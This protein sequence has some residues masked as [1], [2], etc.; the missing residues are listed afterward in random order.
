MLTDWIS[1]MGSRHNLLRLLTAL[2]LLN[3]TLCIP[4][5]GHTISTGDF[6]LRLKVLSSTYETING[7]SQVPI[8]CDL[9]NYSAYCNESRNAVG[10]NVMVVQDESG[11]TLTISCV[12]DS[13]W[14]NC[15]P[16]PVGATF[17]AREDKQGILVMFLNDKGKG[18]KQLYQLVAASPATASASP[19]PSA[20]SPEAPAHSEAATAPE[21]HE[22]PVPET[23][24]LPQATGKIPCSFSSTPSGAEIRVDDQYV[25]NTPSEIGLSAGQH[26]IAVSMPGYER[27][28]RELTV[29][30][31]SVVN[32]SAALQ[33]AQ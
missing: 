27:W 12:Q 23:A 4:G 9:S 14:S 13:R 21:L 8:D 26:E 32:V 11:N 15:V 31:D 1:T 24:A 25:G 10:S 33:K 5:F 16:I 28:K 19:E 20:A 29:S 6:P 18:R 17:A 3:I 2:F 30:G 7:G 22:S